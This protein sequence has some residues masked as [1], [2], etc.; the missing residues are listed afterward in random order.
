MARRSGE[1]N[2]ASFF[3]P[4]HHPDERLCGIRP[5]FFHARVVTDFLLCASI[6]FSDSPWH[7]STPVLHRQALLA[8]ALLPQAVIRLWAVLGKS[9]SL[10][11][12][13]FEVEVR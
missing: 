2:R 10:G 12:V 4:L 1:V 6:L 11:L 3:L 9:G 7:L 13:A 8:L 5:L